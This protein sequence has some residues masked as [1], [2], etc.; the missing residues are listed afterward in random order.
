MVLKSVSNRY[1]SVINLFIGYNDTLGEDE[2]FKVM[3]INITIPVTVEDET[4]NFFALPN[5]ILINDDDINERNE[6]FGLVVERIDTEDYEVCFQNMYY[7]GRCY[8]NRGV[9]EILIVDTDRKCLLS[10]YNTLIQSFYIFS[11]YCWVL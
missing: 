5:I 6:S 4:T 8:D 2:D 10:T 1:E 3:S 7:G 11:F 9:V